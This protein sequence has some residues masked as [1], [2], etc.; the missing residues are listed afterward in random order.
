[1]KGSRPGLQAP[2]NQT[3]EAT[4]SRSEA[5]KKQWAKIIGPEARAARIKKVKNNPKELIKKILE[6]ERN[7]NSGNI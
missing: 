2:R 1:M 6:D 4:K 5:S 3:P 7:H